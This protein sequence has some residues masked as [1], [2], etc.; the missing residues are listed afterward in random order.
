MKQREAKIPAPL[1]RH[2]TEAG[3]RVVRLYDDWGKPK[4]AA[5]WRAKLASELPAEN[6]EPKP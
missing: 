4:E 6:N 5:D 2:L 1:K 3:E